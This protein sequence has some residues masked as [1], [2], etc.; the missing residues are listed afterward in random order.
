MKRFN[1]LF[2]LAV[3]I[4]F[5][6]S[7][8][9]GIENINPPVIVGLLLFGVLMFSLV[10]MADT[11]VVNYLRQRFGKNLLSALVPLAGLYILTIGYLAML[12]QLTIMQIIIPLIY[13]FLPAL[14]LWW[15]RQT[16]QHINWRNLIAILVV[17]FFIE[18]G[19][20]PAASIPPEKGISFFM[21]IA[22]NGI[23]Y[24]FLVLRGLDSIG[25]R[26]RP[27]VEDWKY[28]CLYLGLFIAF[29]AVPI[30]FLTSFI[31][32]TTDWQPLWKF[33]IILLGIFLFT[34][35]PEEILFRGL[36][37]NLLAGRLK[38]NQSELP[39]L[40][41]SSIIFGL[42]HVNNSDPPFIFVHLFGMDWS[43]PWAYVILATIAGWFYGLAYIRTRSILAP[44]MLHAMVDGWW[45]Y[46]FNA[47]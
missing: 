28:A 6:A 39:V 5:T 30:G 45:S 38:K 22:L 17:W 27:N 2:A 11:E 32:Q 9:S 34:G 10:G 26:L 23:I 3:L 8:L 14:L 42:A 46:F 41:I 21:L 19:L 44:A 20:V 35:L 18:L 15:D 4:I 47:S 1:F 24:S 37:H 13:L 31:G 33:P 25:Y 40:L 43:I 36:I 12:D 16:P 29:F 7:V